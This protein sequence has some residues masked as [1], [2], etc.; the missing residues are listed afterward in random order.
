MKY[1]QFENAKAIRVVHV[2]GGG[3]GGV[4]G[5][6]GSGESALMT[7][8]TSISWSTFLPTRSHDVI[9]RDRRRQRRANVGV[10]NGLSSDVIK[11]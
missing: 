4:G 3:G 10:T 9:S 6:G 8:D 7:I 5:S 1:T 2:E 11:P